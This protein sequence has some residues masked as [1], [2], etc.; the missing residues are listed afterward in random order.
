MQTSFRATASNKPRILIT[1]GGTFLG[2]SIAAALLAEGADVTMIV[3][4]GAE[5][6]LGPLAQRVRWWHADIW[7]TAS[8][9]GRG[10]GHQMVIHTI[11]SLTADPTRGLSHHRLNFVSARNAATMCISDGVPELMLIST[12]RAPWINRRYM[13]SKR[14]A[15]GYLGRVGVQGTIIRAPLVY[16]RGGN[17]PPFFTLMTL[18]GQVPPFRWLAPGRVAPMPVDVLARG[19]AR[20]ALDPERK[21]QIY[22]AGDLRRRNRRAERTQPVSV[23]PATTPAADLDDTRPKRG[24]LEQLDQEL[25]FGWSPPID[26]HEE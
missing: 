2:D 18:L 14:E 21:K 5:V 24:P 25:P 20:I 12:V 19:V 11:G 1:G 6:N 17:R 16:T 9:R 8:M 13:R 26:E 7:D 3:R 22:Y 10:R 23:A 4:S 15:E